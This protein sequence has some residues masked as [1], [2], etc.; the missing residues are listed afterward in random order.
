MII[1]T[2]CLRRIFGKGVNIICM[3]VVPIVLN[4]VMIALT[5]QEVQY[6]VGI[7]DKDNTRFTKAFVEQ[8]EEKYNYKIVQ[9]KEDEVNSAVINKDVDCALEFTKGLT[10]E[11]IHG[12][13][14]EAKFYALSDSNGSEPLQMNIESFMS[15]MKQIGKACNEDEEVFYKG[16]ESYNKD[17][18]H[19]VYK[20]S[21]SSTSEDVQ[22]AV[23]SLG[24]VAI[25]MVFLMTF[26]TMLILQD[27]V[28]GVFDRLNT[29]PLSRLS[30]YTQHLLSY[31]VV[32]LI[33]IVV[34][35][36]MLPNL[37]DVKFGNTVT[38][39]LEV[40]IGCSAFAIVC[41]AIGITVSRFSKNTMVA[42][43]FI[44][45]INIPML[46]LGGCFWPREI[47]PKAVQSV[48]NF[49]P[50]TWF[51]KASESILYGDAISDC[52]QPIMY[53]FALSAL[54]IVITFA[55]RTEKQ[56]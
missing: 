35:V 49:M 39:Q 25:G 29:T 38:Q 1:F 32:A 5:T 8:I 14:V 51:L 33:Q 27:K 21:D 42:G 56:R 6:N 20:T 18:Y 36:D 44:S 54:L 7:V 53:L 50:T 12:K 23:S 17:S 16:V 24:Y 26:S 10:D 31:F 11:I 55:V 9:L 47:M 41:I 3:I 15:A 22:R 19:L 43:S 13:D 52:I 30:Y 2:N 46:M 28:K 4:I 40:I 37:V 45:L 34:M 48:G